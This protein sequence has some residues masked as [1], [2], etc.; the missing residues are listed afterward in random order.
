MSRSMVIFP[1]AFSLG[2]RGGV[3]GQRGAQRPGG[4]Q[5]QASEGR[6]ARDAALH[7]VMGP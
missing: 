7:D 6:R 2:S 1:R 3:P 4:D 5:T